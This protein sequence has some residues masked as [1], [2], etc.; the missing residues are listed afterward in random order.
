MCKEC[1]NGEVEETEHFV[2]RCAYVVKER[3]RLENVISSKVKGWHELG[4]NKKVVRI[5]D[6]VGCDEAVA[7]ESLWKK[8]FVA[9][10]PI[11]NQ[12]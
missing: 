7:V 3:K 11:P 2:M 5:I 12:T 4:D 6:R 10:A 8:R 1:R 9:D